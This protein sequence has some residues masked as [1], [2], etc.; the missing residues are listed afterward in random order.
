MAS[1]GQRLVNLGLRGV[2]LCTRF[3]FVF[4]LARYLAPAAVGY[5]GLFTA[6]VGYALY[7]VGLDFHIYNMRELLRAPHE[8]RG[9]LIR[10]QAVLTAGLY[11][12]L[13]PVAFILPASAGWPPGLAY[14]FLP[15][16]VLEHV[17]QEISRILIALSDQVGA[18]VLLFVRQGSWAL[19]V[20]AVMAWDPVTRQLQDVMAGWGAAGVVAA[21]LGMWKIARV[22]M[23]GWRSAIDWGWIRRG[24]RISVAFLSATLALRAL[25]IVD[26]YWLKALVDI[27]AVGA[28]VLFTGIASTLM[29]FLDAG[30]FA[31]SYPELI[32]LHHQGRHEA[33]RHRLRTMLVHTL[34]LS[35]VFSLV[36]WAAL[37]QLLAWIH[38]P[39]YTRYLWLYPWVL[40]ATVLYGVGMVPHYALYSNGVD[41]PIIRSHIAALLVFPLTVWGLSRFRPVLAVPLGLNIAFAT[42][43]LWKAAAYLRVSRSR[44]GPATLPQAT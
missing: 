36:S 40:S 16:L 43:L 32:Q 2:T 42:I 12:L 11:A 1:R 26:R 23:S 21:A 30:I 38:N 35:A 8:Q 28:Y 4:F 20:V 25:Q 13:L 5:Y 18:S 29:V 15:I 9:R 31:F 33:L 41:R 27:E 37:P 10:D 44:G 7:C 14:W 17:N 22:R 6:T 19:L 24:V 39:V 3:L 34:L